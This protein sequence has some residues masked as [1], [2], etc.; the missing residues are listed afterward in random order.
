MA[1]AN[2]RYYATGRRKEAVARVWVSPGTGKLKVNGVP[3]ID[4]FKRKTLEVMVSRPLELTD[5]GEKVDVLARVKGGGI[6]GQAG[7]L[8]LGIARALVKMD[9][10]VKPLLRNNGILTRDPRMVERKKSGQRG[11][12]ARFQFTK[13]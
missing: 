4:Y 1:E 2:D 11:A 7:A 3:P 9:E 8:R 10:K 5:M 12:R 13:R 6:S